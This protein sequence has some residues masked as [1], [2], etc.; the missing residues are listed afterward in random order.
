MVYL[1]IILLLLDKLMKLF[2]HSYYPDVV[3][4]VKLKKKKTIN[5]PKSFDF[6]NIA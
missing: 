4:Y 6:Y 5:I 1:N 3:E 2:N